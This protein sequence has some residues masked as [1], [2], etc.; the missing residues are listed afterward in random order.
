MS[1]QSDAADLLGGFVLISFVDVYTKKDKGIDALADLMILRVATLLYLQLLFRTVYT[2]E[3]MSIY[4][5]YPCI[6]CFANTSL[7]EQLLIYV[8]RFK[9][10]DVVQLLRPLYQEFEVLFKESFSVS[11]NANFLWKIQVHF[12]S[13]SL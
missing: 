8:D 2:F 13:F 6:C 9:P 5:F 12:Y 10:V 7:H 3:I 1:T 11:K 4:A